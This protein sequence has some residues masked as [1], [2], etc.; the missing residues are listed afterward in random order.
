MCTLTNDAI[1][2]TRT[3]AEPEPEPE[4]DDSLTVFTD[5]NDTTYVENVI[6]E[7][8]S[9]KYINFNVKNELKRCTNWY[10]C[11]KYW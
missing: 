7:L 6:G 9:S 4:P 11:N 5:I 2:L 10:K 8:N 3:G 1:Y